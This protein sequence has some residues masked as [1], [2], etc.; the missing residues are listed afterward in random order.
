LSGEKL[1]VFKLPQS[2]DALKEQRF[3]DAANRGLN[4]KNLE[5]LAK[6]R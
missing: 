4:E 1:G 5:E 6:L 2:A 3:V